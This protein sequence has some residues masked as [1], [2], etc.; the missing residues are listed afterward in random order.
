ASLPELPQ[1][2]YEIFQKKYG[3]NDYDAS[4]LTEDKS[5]ADYYITLTTHTNNY[6]SEANW[7]LGPVKQ[8]LNEINTPI[9]E[10]NISI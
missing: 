4:Q 9:K 8:Y 6:K 1:T 5:I 2:Q 7:L 3:L 10:A